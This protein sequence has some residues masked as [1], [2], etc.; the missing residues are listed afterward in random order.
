MSGYTLF[1][2]ETAL[3]VIDTEVEITDT[4]ELKRDKVTQ[5]I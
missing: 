5:P 1:S 4:R 2:S 3:I